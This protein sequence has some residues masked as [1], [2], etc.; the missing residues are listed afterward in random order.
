[1]RRVWYDLDLRKR[2][3]KGGN[4][5]CLR[6]IRLHSSHPFSQSLLGRKH[7]G[8]QVDEVSTVSALP[9]TR[10]SNHVGRAGQNR[11]RNAAKDFVKGDIHAVKLLRNLSILTI[12]K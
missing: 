8:I 2:C 4:L 1:M 3:E 9:G 6:M 7:K 10:L 12:V 5:L 11:S